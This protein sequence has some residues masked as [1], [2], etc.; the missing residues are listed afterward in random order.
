MDAVQLSGQ[1][2][3]YVGVLGIEGLLKGFLSLTQ[4]LS[5]TLVCFYVGRKIVELFLYERRI[6]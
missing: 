5:L 1:G 3:A 4:G 2:P 6:T